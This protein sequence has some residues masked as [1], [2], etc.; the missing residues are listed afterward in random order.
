MC[1]SFVTKRTTFFLHI[2]P[3]PIKPDYLLNDLLR[4][5]AQRR[6]SMCIITE[7]LTAKPKSVSTLP[8]YPQIPLP[9]DFS[10]SSLPPFNFR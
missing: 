5:G 9:S 6:E 8:S 3:L 7:V 4:L 1:S 2:L 10:S